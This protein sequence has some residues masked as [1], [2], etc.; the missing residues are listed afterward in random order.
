VWMNVTE[1]LTDGENVQMLVYMCAFNTTW[2][3]ESQG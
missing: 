2:S 3:I 1:V